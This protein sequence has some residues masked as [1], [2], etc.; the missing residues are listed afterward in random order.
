MQQVNININRKDLSATVWKD[1]PMSECVSC[2]ICLNQT[3]FLQR[4]K[5]LRRYKDYLEARA[6]YKS[7]EDR[8]T[9]LANTGDAGDI[10]NQTSLLL[11]N[12]NLM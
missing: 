3:L 1:C 4:G 2:S 9:N 12:F 10:W 8:G 7:E 11:I 5:S 6:E